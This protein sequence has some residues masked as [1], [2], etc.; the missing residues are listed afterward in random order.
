MKNISVL[1]LLL[2]LW[3]CTSEKA[4]SLPQQVNL[5]AG[6]SKLTY[7]KPNAKA[8]FLL[9]PIG[10]NENTTYIQLAFEHGKH[11]FTVYDK[12]DDELTVSKREVELQ[13]VLPKELCFEF[14]G[15]NRGSYLSIQ[16]NDKRIILK[17]KT[18]KDGESQSFI[19]FMYDEVEFTNFTIK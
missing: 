11:M 13:K 17:L 4:P 16:P 2:V 12:T 8:G 9:E 3:I 14:I 6:S 19:V 1:A 18:G 7:L 15:N 10:T 5:T